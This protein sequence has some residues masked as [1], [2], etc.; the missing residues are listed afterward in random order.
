[1]GSWC[2]DYLL[3]VSFTYLWHGFRLHLYKPDEYGTIYWYLTRM[4]QDRVQNSNVRMYSVMLAAQEGKTKHR[5]GGKKKKLATKLKNSARPLTPFLHVQSELRLAMCYGMFYVRAR[6]AG[7]ACF[8]LCV[9]HAVVAVLLASCAC[10]W[11]R[12]SWCASRRCHT[13]TRCAGTTTGSVSS[14]TVPTP[15]ARVS[16]SS[17][18]TQTCPPWVMRSRCRW[19]LS[20]QASTSA[21][22]ETP[23]RGCYLLPT[24]WTSR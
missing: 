4:Y 19:R 14:W 3:R 15:D 20:K 23:R 7:W 18:R 22:Q 12:R 13:A 1:M 5:K 24:C 10:A 11:R 8:H 16:T 2:I 21:A 6:G 9:A 17:W